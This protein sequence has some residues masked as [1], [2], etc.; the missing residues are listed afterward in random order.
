MVVVVRWFGLGLSRSGCDAVLMACS[1]G[2]GEDEG[3]GKMRRDEGGVSPVVAEGLCVG[4]RLAGVGRSDVEKR[5]EKELGT[6]SRDPEITQEVLN[7]AA[8][9][10][11]LYK[12]PNQAYQLLE[13]KVLLNLDWAK[14]Q[15]TKSSL[16]KTVAFTNEGSNNFDNDNIMARMDAM[17]LKIDARID[18][19]D[20]ILEE[21]FD[22]L[23]DEALRHLFNKQNAKPRL[24]QWI[25]LLQEFDIEIKDRK[26]TENVA[27][28]YLSLI[29]NDDI[30]DD[31]EVDDNF[32]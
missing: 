28:D 16:K 6:R 13:Y 29:E 3:G 5:E 11:F 26:G 2:N 32:R 21:D 25:L 22:S 31:S 23:L 20:E 10:I 15:K 17:I 12:T 19:I 9:G 4:G 18:V 14:N 27:A 8:G 30:I 24:I 7:A 1:E